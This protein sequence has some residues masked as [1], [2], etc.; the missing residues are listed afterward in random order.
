MPAPMHLH[1]Q[2]RIEVALGRDRQ[3]MAPEPEPDGVAVAARAVDA[4]DHDRA[5]RGG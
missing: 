4:V 1:D 3:P 5:G 2:Q